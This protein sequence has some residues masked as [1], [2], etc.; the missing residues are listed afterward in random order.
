M[1]VCALNRMEFQKHFRPA[2]RSRHRR[3]F[4]LV[5]LL[6]VIGIIAVLVSI[7]I[8]VIS[9]ARRQAKNV[10]CLANVRSL[11]AAFMSYLTTNRHAPVYLDPFTFPS[12][13]WQANL[14]GIYATTKVQLCPETTTN[15]NPA[16]TALTYGTATTTYGDPQNAGTVGSYGLNGFLYFP[17]D[18]DQIAGTKGQKPYDR[19]GIKHAFPGKTTN[20]QI[21]P[22]LDEYWFTDPLTAD[23]GALSQLVLNETAP[24]MVPPPTGFG[25]VANV[26]VFADCNRLDGWP[27]DTDPNPSNGGYT[28]GTGDQNA[29]NGGHGLGRFCMDR[30]PGGINVVFL[31]GHA[32]TVPLVQLWQLRWNKDFRPSIP[33][34]F[35]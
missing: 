4:T 27:L 19:G 12:G 28:L 32:S 31:D 17:N 26:P 24:F 23:G 33:S 25:G 11:G 30:H 9:R 2:G 18:P 15:N 20:A 14:G 22:Y 21:Q 6:V 13:T 1:S 3:A 8:P 10:Q 34:P 7:L 5:E 35:P 29:A 16:A